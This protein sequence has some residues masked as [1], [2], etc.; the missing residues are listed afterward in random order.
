MDVML[1]ARLSWVM[2]AKANPAAALR[3]AV[4]ASKCPSKNVTIAIKTP[5]MGAGQDA[6][7]RSVFH[8]PSTTAG[9][10]PAAPPVAMG[11]APV[12]K[13]ATIIIDRMAMGAAK[14]VN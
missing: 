8:A 9:G 6:R 2:G 10:V 13:P 7:L 3:N 4:M 12:R 11:F 14:P 5:E 1:Y